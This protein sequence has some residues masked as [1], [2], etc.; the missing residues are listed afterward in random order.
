MIALWSVGL[1][2]AAPG[3]SV[4][5]EWISSWGPDHYGI[6]RIRSHAEP[7]LQLGALLVGGT[8][9]AVLGTAARAL[10]LEPGARLQ[11][12]L[13]LGMIRSS[14]AAPG[15]PVGGGELA[16]SAPVGDGLALALALD[17]AAGLGIRASAGVERDLSERWRLSPRLRLDTLAG[18]RDPA[19]R[20]ATTLAWHGS[21]GVHVSAEL[22]AGGRDVLHLGPGLALTVGRW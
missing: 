17:G 15:G 19:L 18:A 3:G 9:S 6:L 14:S 11:L 22:S 1:A 13:W 7:G 16:L 21:D 8:R 5:A 10:E 12:G 2:A 20:A 4:Q